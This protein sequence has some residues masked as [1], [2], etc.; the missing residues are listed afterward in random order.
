VELCAF[1]KAFRWG[2]ASSSRR[3]TNAVSALSAQKSDLMKKAASTVDL[4]R[5]LS[6]LMSDGKVTRR[7]DRRLA[8]C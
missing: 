2:V 3:R 1:G 7:G 5:A 4:G 6:L 8:R